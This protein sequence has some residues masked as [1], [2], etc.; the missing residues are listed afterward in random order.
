MKK[1]LFFALATLMLSACTLYM[2]EEPGVNNDDTL[3]VYTGEGYDS[4]VHEQDDHMDAYYQFQ[5]NV[6]L[7]TEQMQSYIVRMKSDPDELFTYIDFDIN[8]P[9]ELL[10]VKGDVLVSLE[11]AHFPEGFG[12]HVLAIA[13]AGSFY[14]CLTCV[15]DMKDIFKS[16]TLDATLMNPDAPQGV[17]TRD[18]GEGQEIDLGEK[19]LFTETF[20]PSGT[21]TASKP[22]ENGKTLSGSI[23]FDPEKNSL[24]I[25]CNARVKIADNLYP[26]VFLT[27][28]HKGEWDFD[29]SGGMEKSI[30]L[31]EK[32]NLLPPKAK[33]KVGPVIVKFILGFDFSA[34]LNF[35]A[36]GRI[37]GTTSHEAETNI[38]TFSSAT[39]LQQLAYMALNT[40]T[41]DGNFDLDLTKCA[42][43]GS[44]GWKLN[45]SAGVGL[46]TKA[47]SARLN[48]SFYMGWQGTWDVIN[49][50]SS[51]VDISEYNSCEFI[52]KLGAEA[53]FMINLNLKNVAVEAFGDFFDDLAL[54]LDLTEYIASGNADPNADTDNIIV[55]EAGKKYKDFKKAWDEYQA[56]VEEDDTSNGTA[57][58]TLKEKL[59]G[60]W[61]FSFWSAEKVIDRFHTKKAIYPTVSDNDLRIVRASEF[62]NNN[63][64][65]DFKGSFLLAQSGASVTQDRKTYYPALL[66][67]KVIDENTEVD[68]DI[69]WPSEGAKYINYLTYP[70]TEYTFNMENLDVG[71]RYMGYP[72]YSD[73]DHGDIRLIDRGLPFGANTPLF[74]VEEIYDISAKKVT[75]PAEGF[76]PARPGYE[77]RLKTRSVMNGVQ[78]Y[79]VNSG[80][81]EAILESEN[82]TER[83]T[84]EYTDRVDGDVRWEWIF[85]SIDDHVTI[86]FTPSLK[87][88]DPVTVRLYTLPFESKVIELDYKTLNKK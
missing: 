5:P 56:Y 41:K 40:N 73:K 8:T 81:V 77:Y 64:K 25:Y 7:F 71:A 19:Q 22:L 51:F 76:N 58:K 24:D 12:N 88:V 28:G 68:V 79:H 11:T 33:V 59:K 27:F 30:T 3:P 60:P 75:L 55:T 84:M 35:S 87:A 80:K 42:L 10:P 20:H 65:A 43:T 23:S 70:Y 74:T 78:A 26:Q 16:L 67:R 13:N 66:V 63:K 15:A 44:I 36:T 45:V 69:F 54:L 2:D 6:R 61:A 83:R 57:E 1:I 34:V 50:R 37:T 48:P 38:P 46:F 86:K 14:R 82:N 39:P 49:E 31:F 52:P 4:V 32:K 72:C 85:T 47:V 17:R 62:K 9:A 18:D 53:V 21:Y 29:V